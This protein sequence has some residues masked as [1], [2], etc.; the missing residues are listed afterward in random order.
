MCEELRKLGGL[1]LL[2]NNFSSQKD[3][4]RVASARVLEQS[5]TPENCNYVVEKGIDCL[6][7]I[8]K[9]ATALCE[10]EDASVGTGILKQLFRH[11]ESTCTDVLRLQG[12]EKVTGECRRTDVETLRNCAGALVNLSLYG[13]P[14]NQEAMIKKRVHMWL[15]PLAFNGDDAVKYSACLAISVL[16]TNKEI[17]AQ[18]IKTSR[19]M[20]HKYEKKL[21]TI[22][23]KS[24][25]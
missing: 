11:S 17:E 23:I 7:R 5:L 25:N 18:I 6:D 15:F 9:V 24:H 4:V 20:S 3:E 12:L 13:G 8:V 19:F 1:D 22:R 10:E 16:V 2:L 14:E 21:P